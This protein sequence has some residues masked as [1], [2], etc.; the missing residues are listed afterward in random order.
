MTYTLTAQP[1]IIVRDED[2]AFIPND[3]DNKDYAEYLAWCEEGNTAKAYI[4]PPAAK[5]E[6]R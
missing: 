4:P 2:Q 3:P 6:R 5:E 1:N